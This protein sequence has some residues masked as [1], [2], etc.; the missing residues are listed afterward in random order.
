VTLDVSFVNTSVCPS[1]V[2]YVDGGEETS[3]EPLS[4]VLAVP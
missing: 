1:G 4:V 3:A 2:T